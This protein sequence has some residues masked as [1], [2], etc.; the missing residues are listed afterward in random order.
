MAYATSNPPALQVQ[1]IAGPRRWVYVSADPIAT[2]NT[3]GYIS[4]GDA[5]GMKVGDLV[6]VIDT[7]TPTTSL[8]VVADVTA[9]GQADLTDGTAVTRTDTD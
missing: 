7:A 5:L 3:A 1:S 2:V 8:S 6:E 4:N 9:L